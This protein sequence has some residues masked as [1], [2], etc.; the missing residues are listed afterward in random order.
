MC[1]LCGTINITT[2]LG[3][4]YCGSCGRFEELDEEIEPEEVTQEI[5]P[6]T[7][8]VLDTFQRPW[9][10]YKGIQETVDREEGR[11]L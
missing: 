2:K 8:L 6:E 4:S 3:L 10:D 5:T 7:Q 11:D 1:L 9:Y